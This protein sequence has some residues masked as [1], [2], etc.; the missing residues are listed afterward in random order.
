MNK[1]YPILFIA[2]L[3]FFPFNSF[4]KR[5]KSDV[6]APAKERKGFVVFK[7]DNS[8]NDG[9]RV[10]EAFVILD[11]YDRTAA[12]YVRQKFDVLDNKITISDLPEG[13]YFADVYLKGNYKQHFS[14][15]ITVTKKGSAYTFKLEETDTFIPKKANIPAESN[16]FSKT[17]VA[18]M[19]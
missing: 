2:I 8:V 10:S 18:K 7:L 6:A 4:A 1:F 5:D 15:V 14:K 13:K 19:K 12:G 3:F 9:K 17:S 11:K 16:D